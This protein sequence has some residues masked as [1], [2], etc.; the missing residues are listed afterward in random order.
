MLLLLHGE[1]P[2][3]LSPLQSIQ[4]PHLQATLGTINTCGAELARFLQAACPLTRMNDYL[5]LTRICLSAAAAAFP[6][7][8]AA[9]CPAALQRQSCLHSATC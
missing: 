8:V 9:S 4:K 7:V 5:V 3:L 1:C 2:L 6:D